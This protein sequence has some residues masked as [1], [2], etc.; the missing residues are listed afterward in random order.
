MGDAYVRCDRES[1]HCT[2]EHTDVESATGIECTRADNVQHAVP[3]PSKLIQDSP[4]S[5]NVDT[6]QSTL[7]QLL[8][9]D[10]LLAAMITSEAHFSL[11]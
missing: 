7:G 6:Q 10:R 5:S 11:V 8:L 2:D 9:L 4:L 3:E 1:T